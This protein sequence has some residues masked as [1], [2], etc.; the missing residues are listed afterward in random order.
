MDDG[1]EWSLKTADSACPTQHP[2]M[3]RGGFVKRNLYILVTG[4]RK[5][6]IHAKLTI[7]T[8]YWVTSLPGL[9]QVLAMVSL[10]SPYVH[11]ALLLGLYTRV[12]KLVLHTLFKALRRSSKSPVSQGLGFSSTPSLKV[13][14]LHPGL[15]RC[16]RGICLA[17]RCMGIANNSP[18]GMLKKYLP[19]HVYS[20]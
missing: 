2:L 4:S 13:H 20:S 12:W 6:H 18:A 14:V 15:I 7:I 17:E 19:T 10:P 5:A 3:L 16:P 11:T 8:K 1:L 9:W